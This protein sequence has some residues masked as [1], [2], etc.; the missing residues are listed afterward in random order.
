[1]TTEEYADDLGTRP[2][3]G[4]IDT[5]AAAEISWLR[6]AL[7]ATTAELADVMGLDEDA[8]TVMR[9]TAGI[10]YL[11]TLGGTT[12]P[13]R[14]AREQLQGRVGAQ[15]ASARV[16]RDAVFK[17]VEEAENGALEAVQAEDNARALEALQRLAILRVTFPGLAAAIDR[18]RS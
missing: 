18:R 1:M 3:L 5:A 7:A 9:R 17:A 11:S 15:R 10:A 12:T 6:S 2:I 14:E 4:V 16:R 13:Q 8:M